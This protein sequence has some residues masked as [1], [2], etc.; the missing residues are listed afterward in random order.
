MEQG[1][2]QEVDII[3]VDQEITTLVTFIL[4]NVKVT[5]FLRAGEYYI[6][7]TLWNQ[8]QLLLMIWETFW[9]P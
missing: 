8:T 3:F 5:K 9:I 7:Y 1:N 2:F 6:H 4:N